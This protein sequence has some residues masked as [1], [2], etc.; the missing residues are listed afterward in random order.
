MGGRVENGVESLI[1]LRVTV[2]WIKSY[3]ICRY[4]PHKECLMTYSQDNY[5]ILYH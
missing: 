1:A 2:D 4:V 5:A 3:I